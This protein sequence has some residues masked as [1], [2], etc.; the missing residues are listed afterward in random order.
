MPERLVITRR[1]AILGGLA[2]L[3]GCQG[4]PEPDFPELV[5]ATGPPGAVFREIGA[6]LAEAL[7]RWLPRTRV[8]ALETG[9]STENLRLL[10]EGTA[11]VGFASLDSVVGTDGRPPRRVRALGRIYDSHLHL[12]VPAESA[13]RGFADLDG[14]RV[15]YGAEESGTEHTVERLMELT[16]RR[17]EDVR[18]DQAASADALAAGEIDALFSLTGIPTPAISD[19]VAEDRVRLVPLRAQADELAEAYPGPY[20]PATVPPTAYPGVPATDTAAIPNL[21]V[22]RDD[23]PRAMAR[24]VTSTVFTRSEAISADRPEAAHINVRTGIATGPVPL[25][26]GAEDWFRER[27]Q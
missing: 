22:T 19:L 9:A 14:L 13:I 6:A 5:L 16:G 24:I 1:A 4:R 8:T 20:V 18:L 17:T 11:H 21:L 23:F 26:L 10:R 15:S 7:R 12:V 2:A 27:K 3:S 25:H